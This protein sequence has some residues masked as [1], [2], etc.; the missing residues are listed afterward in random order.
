MG[1]KI[2][3]KKRNVIFRKTGDSSKYPTYKSA[4]GP[5]FKNV[6]KHGMVLELVRTIQFIIK[7]E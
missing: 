5:F 1:L 6:S 2:R 4:S 7:D 3:A